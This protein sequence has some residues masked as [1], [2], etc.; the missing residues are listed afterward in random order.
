MQES[1][2][3][4]QLTQ[5]ALALRSGTTKSYISRIENSGSDIRFSTLMKII[6]EGL[7]AKLNLSAENQ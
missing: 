6:N 7:G 3:F 2:K 4:R 1:R 5:H